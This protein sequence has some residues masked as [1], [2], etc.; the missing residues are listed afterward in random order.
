MR[1]YVL[2]TLMGIHKV[3]M[4][5]TDFDFPTPNNRRVKQNTESSLPPLPQLWCC[6]VLVCVIVFRLFSCF[7][8]VCLSTHT[9]F[10]NKI[11]LPFKSVRVW[12][13][14]WD[15]Y[16]ALNYLYILKQ[17]RCI[18]WWCW[19]QKRRQPLIGSFWAQCVS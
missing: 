3:F 13:W 7:L 12:F 17:S 6:P 19:M 14:P 18:F 4:T 5:K 9:V 1:E 8:N 15:S 2:G 11:L 16:V 10:L